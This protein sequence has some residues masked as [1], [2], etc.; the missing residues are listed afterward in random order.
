MTIPYLNEQENAVVEKLAA[1][2]DLSCAGVVRQA[3]RL[4]QMVHAESVRGNRMGFFNDDGERTD[5]PI[6]L[7]CLD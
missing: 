5:T 2:Q 1:E 3:V 6:G 7:G 4:Y